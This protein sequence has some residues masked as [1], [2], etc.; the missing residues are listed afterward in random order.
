MQKDAEAKDL[1]D[2]F[3]YY[4]NIKD[5]SERLEAERGGG[6]RKT[7]KRKNKFIGKKY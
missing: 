5:G 4:C 7:P 3:F 1:K 2:N 6:D